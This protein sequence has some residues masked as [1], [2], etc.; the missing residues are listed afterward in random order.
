[1]IC[2]NEQ[3]FN[4]VFLSELVAEVYRSSQS[5]KTWQQ[6]QQKEALCRVCAVRY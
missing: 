1:M 5:Y 2:F 4:Q 6:K 3:P